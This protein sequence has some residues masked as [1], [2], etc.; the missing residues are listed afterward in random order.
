MKTIVPH[1]KHKAKYG[2]P[3]H[4][5]YFT[6]NSR[7]CNYPAP[8]STKK[9]VKK[10]GGGEDERSFWQNRKRK[11]KTGGPKINRNG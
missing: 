2:T 1:R 5:L 6:D 4:P 7:V 3:C 9:K 8:T 10:W 11:I